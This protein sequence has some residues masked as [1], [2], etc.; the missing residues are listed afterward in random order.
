MPRPPRAPRPP[1]PVIEVEGRRYAVNAATIT[2][3]R[4]S[5]AD[6]QV[7]DSGVSRKHIAIERRGDRVFVKDLGST[8]G[9][10]VNGARL[11][12]E[13]ELL[14]GSVVTAGHTR[15]TFHLVPDQSEVD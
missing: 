3:G 15:V 8:N 2:I 7:S 12:P 4:S 5:E 13:A 10:F 6:I 14:D 9:S 11:D 1:Q